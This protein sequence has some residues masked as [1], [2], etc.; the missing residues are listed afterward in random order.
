MKRRWSAFLIIT[1]K[2]M[3]MG[4][5]DVV[6]GVSGGTIAF[7]T[8]IY[9]ELIDSIPV[10]D[11]KIRWDTNISLPSE[12]VMRMTDRVGCRFSP[13]CPKKMDI[14]EQSLPEMIQVEEDQVDGMFI[15]DNRQLVGRLRFRYE[16][17]EVQR[18]DV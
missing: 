7:I 4:A 8:G 17:D 10:P 13:R 5:A 2:G 1:L 6:P 11:P 12:E 18:I 3:G 14:C 15:Q 16:A 9:K